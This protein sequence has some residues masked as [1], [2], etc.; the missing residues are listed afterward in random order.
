MEKEA[1]LLVFRQLDF[2]DNNENLEGTV[3][4]SAPAVSNAKQSGKGIEV[5]S[6]GSYY[7]GLFQ[8]G[9]KQGYGVYYWA[10]GSKY[11]GNW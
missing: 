10:D 11:L 5:W 3:D 1:E 2:L 9:V 8:Q 6:D 4:G 7:H